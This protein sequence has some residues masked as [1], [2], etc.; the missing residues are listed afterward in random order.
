MLSLYE[1]IGPKELKSIVNRFYDLVFESEIQH[2]FKANPDLIRE[3]QFEFLSQ[4]LGGPKLYSKKY[5]HPK[6]RMRHLSHR[7]DE[8]AKLTW[9]KC[10]RQAINEST[11]DR[12]TAEEFYLCFP[13]VT[14]HMQNH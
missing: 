10:M 14:D 5:G 3:K 2:L 12:E 1:K 6:M 4:F 9:L 7:I 8:Q 13:R 11:L